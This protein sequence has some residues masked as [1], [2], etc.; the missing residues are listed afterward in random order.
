M[1]TPKPR[2]TSALGELLIE[3]ASIVCTTAALVGIVGLI[4][5]GNV[6]RLIWEAQAVYWPC[7]GIAYVSRVYQ[8]KQPP[9][10]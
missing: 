9:L 5:T 4:R 1:S 8:D 3:A 10:P 2:L 7:F 6:P